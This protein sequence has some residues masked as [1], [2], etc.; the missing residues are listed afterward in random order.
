MKW[1]LTDVL[2]RY[3][4]P[5]P[6][7][8]RSGFTLIELLAV[9]AIVVAFSTIAGLALR[10]DATA[11]FALRG[12]EALVITLVNLARNEAIDHGRPARWVVHG[13]APPSGDTNLYLRAMSVLREDPINAGHFIAVSEQ[14]ML[15]AGICVVPPAPLAASDIAPGLTWDESVASNIMTT[16]M[17]Y[18]GHAEADGPEIYFGTAGSGR[19]FYLEFDAAGHLI[20]PADGATIALA[21]VVSRIGGTPAFSNPHAVRLTRVRPNGMVSLVVSDDHS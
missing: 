16:S 5:R 2:R 12:G 9:L 11:G 6:R 19:I 1:R 17:S 20:A 10:R 14:V 13:E 7:A 15:P 8:K 18:R 3:R 4:A 21:S